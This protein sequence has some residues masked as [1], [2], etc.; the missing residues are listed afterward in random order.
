LEVIKNEI[1]VKLLITPMEANR[2]D[3]SALH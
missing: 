3:L 2:P 1:E